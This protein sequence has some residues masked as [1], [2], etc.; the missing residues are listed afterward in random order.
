MRIEISRNHSSLGLYT[1]QEVRV[2]LDCGKFLLTDWGRWEDSG[3]WRSLAEI[4]GSLR[5]APPASSAMPGSSGSEGRY[6]PPWE[7]R[8]EI[9]FW[10]ALTGTVTDVLFSPGATFS[11]MKRSGGL[12]GPLWYAI[13]LGYLGMLAAIV[14]QSL[15]SSRFSHL[16]SSRQVGFGVIVF[17]ALVGPIVIALATF[18]SSALLHLMLLIVGGANRPFET[19]F[20][21]ICYASGSA[22]VFNLIP[23]CG[24]VIYSM[25]YL[26]IASIGLARAHETSTGRAVIALLLPMILCCGLGIV[27]VAS[28]SSLAH[29]HSF[30]GNSM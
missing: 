20:R 2:G 11:Q 30:G 19:T 12:R 23:V 17:L 5:Q 25:W 16:E 24:G 15:L 13:I 1:E 14:F 4:A 18:L 6:G 8:A 21:V 28:V 22:M 9:G 10:S 7:Q 27:A 29:L 3:D 26:V